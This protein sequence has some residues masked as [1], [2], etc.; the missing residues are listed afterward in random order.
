VHFLERLDM[1]GKGTEEHEW[2]MGVV[3]LGTS[4]VLEYGRASSVA[5]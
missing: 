4:V 3:N 2:V 5:R 1:E